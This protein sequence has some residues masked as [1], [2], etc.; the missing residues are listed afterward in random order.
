MPPDHQFDEW[1]AANVAPLAVYLASEACEFTGETFFVQG[2]TVT[3][4]ESW[5]MSQS[6]QRR[7]RGA[8]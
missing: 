4:V 3:R 1:D 2:G 6:V 8:G 5:A 7:E